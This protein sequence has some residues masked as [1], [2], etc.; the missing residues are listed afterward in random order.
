MASKGEVSALCVEKIYDQFQGVVQL[1]SRNANSIEEQ[2]L[3]SEDNDEDIADIVSR[4]MAIHRAVGGL[5]LAWRVLKP[6]VENPDIRLHPEVTEIILTAI[7]EA[8]SIL[9]P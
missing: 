5:D 1:L 3:S 2:S 8:R 9:N 4:A 6:A 7:R